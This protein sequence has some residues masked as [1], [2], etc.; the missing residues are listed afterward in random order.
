M[1]SNSKIRPIEPRPGDFFKHY[2]GG[3][4][5]IIA[6]GKYCENPNVDIVIYQDIKDMKNKKPYVRFMSKW[7]EPAKMN[8]VEMIR[9]TKLENYK[10]KSGMGCEA[11]VIKA[12]KEPPDF[13]FEAGLELL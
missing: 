10:A 7:L 2:R 8:D 1:E 12:K 6:I 3:I 5:Y 4:Y 11:E 9:Y 13:R